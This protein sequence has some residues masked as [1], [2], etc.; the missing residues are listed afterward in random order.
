MNDLERYE[1]DRQGYLVIKNLLTSAEVNSLL[2]AVNEV[3]DHATRH[4]NE[5][6]RKKSLWGHEYHCSDRGYHVMGTVGQGNTIVIE[7][8]F[9]TNPAFD[10]LVDHAGTMKYIREIVQGPIHVNNS[11]IRI[12]YTGNKS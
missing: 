11:E 10:V 12:R 5:P 6:P 4:L 1:F 9:N 7:D 2:E 8:F 3:E